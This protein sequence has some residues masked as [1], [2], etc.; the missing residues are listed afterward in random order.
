MTDKNKFALLYCTDGV[1]FNILPPIIAASDEVEIDD[2]KNRMAHVK[3]LPGEPLFAVTGI[4]VNDGIFG[5]VS[6]S[7]TIADGISLMLF[8]YAWGCALQG[9][10]YPLPSTQRLFRGNPVCFDKMDKSFIP[11]LSELNEK[12]QK[13]VH[14]INAKRYFKREYFPDAFLNETKKKAKEENKKYIISN[15]QIITSFLLKKYHHLMMPDAD[16]IKIK[17]PVDFRGI[18]PDIDPLYIGNV[19]FD[20]FTEFYK[21]EIDAMSIYQIAYRLKESVK[22]TRNKNHMKEIAYVTPHGIEFNPEIFKHYPSYNVDTDVVSS[23][24]THFNDLES[25]GIGSDIG[26]FVHVDSTVQTSFIILKEK[27]GRIFAQL[28]SRYPFNNSCLF[29]SND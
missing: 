3:T 1:Q 12:I 6:C 8:L 25:L 27:T 18:H 24:L 10:S 9:K 28:T 15:N 14:A 11:P 7:H 17:I 5:G 2:I 26:R 13:R 16:K 21:N 22:Q 20:S 23:N 4:P 19:V 29:C